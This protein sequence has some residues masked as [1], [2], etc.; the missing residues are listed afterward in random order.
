MYTGILCTSGGGMA[1]RVIVVVV[2][3]D[4]YVM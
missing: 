1:D 3:A 2:S 4:H